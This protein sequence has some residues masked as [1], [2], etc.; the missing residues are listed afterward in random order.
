MI[1][2]C[3]NK[4]I[5]IRKEKKE[6]V[7]MDIFCYSTPTFGYKFEYLNWFSYD[8]RFVF[9]IYLN[10]SVRLNISSVMIAQNEYGAHSVIYILEKSGV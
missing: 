4:I 10:G 6:K 9:L 7:C 3:A 2:K 1:K 8:L 5:I